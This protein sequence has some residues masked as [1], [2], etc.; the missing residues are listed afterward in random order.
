[1]SKTTIKKILREEINLLNHKGEEN[2]YY[3]KDMILQSLQHPKKTVGAEKQS[4]MLLNLIDMFQQMYEALEEVHPKMVTK[5]SFHN[6]EDWDDLGNGEPEKGYL[7]L[8]LLK[9]LMIDYNLLGDEWRGSTPDTTLEDSNEVHNLVID[10][11][12]IITQK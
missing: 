4:T 8:S 12:D 6:I 2:L 5:Y 7:F 10:L 3:L 1:M 11:A 9:G